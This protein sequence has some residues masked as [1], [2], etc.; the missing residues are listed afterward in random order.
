[1]KIGIIGA[2]PA[3]ISVALQLKRFGFNPTIFEKEEIGGAVK[4]AFKIFNFLGYPSGISG[5][6]F[7]KKMKETVK[8]N[9]LKIIFEE[10]KEV[11]YEDKFI[12]KTNK[13]FKF[14]ILVIA[15][16]TYKKPLPPFE[17]LFTNSIIDLKKIK[18]LR[19]GILGGSDVAFDY[20][21]SLKNAKEVLI[22]HKG[23]KP[24]AI[25][26]LRDRVFS[27]KNLRY[28]NNLK[29]LDIKRL[30]NSFQIIFE[31][32]E[33]IKKFNLDYL[34]NAIG[35]LPEK[36]FYHEDFKKMEGDLIEKG[37]LYLAGDVAHPLY[38]QISIALGDGL[39][40]AQKI[41]EKISKL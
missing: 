14:D 36:R 5:K 21:L 1:M 4:E 40:T 8:R 7:V 10:I 20:A 3:G 13:I 16:G 35:R 24:K 25:K 31:K 19:I 18:N 2:G 28:L 15:S 23:K 39:L 11:K 27:L 32:N 12:L 34:I 29:L 38:R 9:K 6:N 37:V 22:F 41:Y 17:S 26:D 30:E 33:K